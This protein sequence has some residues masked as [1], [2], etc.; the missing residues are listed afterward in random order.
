MS[1]KR[2]RGGDGGDGAGGEDQLKEKTFRETLH[3]AVEASVDAAFGAE[4]TR[5]TEEC[6]KLL[7]EANGA[8]DKLRE[9]ATAEAGEILRKARAEREALEVGAVH[10]ECRVVHVECSFE[11]LLV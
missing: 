8:A 5:V 6:T 2:R 7:A 9:D 1:P 11:R 10:V 4:K 3:Q